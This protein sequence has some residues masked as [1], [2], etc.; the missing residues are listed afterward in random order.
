[1]DHSLHG[2]SMHAQAEVCVGLESSG[3]NYLAESGRLKELRIVTSLSD[4]LVSTVNLA[5]RGFKSAS[6]LRL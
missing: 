6:N 3:H 2:C 5:F 1:M 4:F